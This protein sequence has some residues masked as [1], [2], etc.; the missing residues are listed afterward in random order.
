MGNGRQSCRAASAMIKSRLII[1]FGL[2][3]TISPPWA[4][5]AK[6]PIERSISPASCTSSGRNST[7]ND[8]ATA[9]IAA[10]CPTPVV[11]DVITKDRRRA[12]RRAPICLSSSSHFP[13]MPYSNRM[14][15]VALP[16]GRARLM[17]N[18]A[19][20]ASMTLE[21][22]IGIVRVACSN[23]EQ[24]RLP[25]RPD[26]IR[27][28]R[29]QFRR[30]LAKIARHQSTPIGCRCAHCGRRSSPVAPAPAGTPHAGLHFRDR[31]RPGA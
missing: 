23:A 11:V 9:C 21:N 10:N 26:D 22:T 19:P 15:P 1:A 28:E 2:D 4:L 24:L 17:T 16:P 30:V 13:L 29:H 5:P 20:T 31:P 14:K 27:C 12:S 25:W 3:V 6:A 7:A 18:P 8:D